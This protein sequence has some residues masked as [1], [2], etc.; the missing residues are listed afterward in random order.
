MSGACLLLEREIRTDEE[1]VASGV[2]EA[3]DVYD[4]DLSSDKMTSFPEET[5]LGS[6][7]EMGLVASAAQS[8]LVD[9]T[10]EGTL[11]A[12]SLLYGRK[13][14]SDNY[15][16][17]WHQ[18]GV[19]SCLTRRQRVWKGR[20]AL[21]TCRINLE[22]GFNPFSSGQDALETEEGCEEMP[23]SLGRKVEDAAPG[24]GVNGEFF[25]V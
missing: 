3:E 22:K 7:T 21:A 15:G 20:R 13:R 12:G 5:Q 10:S 24:R 19:G 6:S 14:R 8:L 9:D 23:Q 25:V 16:E 4:A 18:F 2:E 1:R 17:D 11:V